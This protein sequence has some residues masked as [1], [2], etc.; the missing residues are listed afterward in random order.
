MVQCVCEN[1]GD[2]FERGASEVARGKAG[3]FCS[4]TCS[5]LSRDYRSRPPEERF[6]ARVR[7]TNSCWLWTGYCTDAGYGQF[8]QSTVS[9]DNEYTH[10]YSYKL[11]HGKIPDGLLVLHHCDVRHCVNPKH[12]YVGT[13]RD[14]TADMDKRGR[15]GSN[16]AIP[17]NVVSEIRVAIK[18]GASLKQI[19]ERFGVSRT[20]AWSIR[21]G[22]TRRKK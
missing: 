8:G 2:K 4:K 21:V 22:R 18:E 3:R 10:R 9:G 7:K 5:N 19:S 14:N 15:R 16:K 13:H 6:W 11:A 1:C 12:L 17:A 20:S